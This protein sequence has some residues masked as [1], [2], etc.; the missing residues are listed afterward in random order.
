MQAMPMIAIGAALLAPRSRDSVIV[1]SQ[2]R[3]RA[4]PEPAPRVAAPAMSCRGFD[5]RA[6]RATEAIER[7]AGDAVELL[8]RKHRLALLVEEGHVR[9][10][11]H[12][13]GGLDDLVLH[14]HALGHGLAVAHDAAE[15]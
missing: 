6:G 8:D 7:C 11:E 12:R 14:V 5:G 2:A 15:A 10:N 3:W 9:A 4:V 1:D 13:I